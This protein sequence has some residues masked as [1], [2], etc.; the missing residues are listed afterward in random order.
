MTPMHE[1]G[2]LL[3]G[4]GAETD[5]PADTII[6]GVC[7]LDDAR[8]GHL[9]FCESQDRVEKLETCPA[10]AILVSRR[11][12]ACAAP[13][14]RVDTPRRAFGRI[15]Q[16]FA[17]EEPMPAGIHPTAVIEAG[18]ELAEGVGV[19]AL[20]YIGA[21]ARIGPNT[22]IMPQ[23][24]IGANASIGA[25]CLLRS[26]VRVERECVLGNRVIVHGGA[27]IGTDGFGFSPGERGIEKE[28]QLGH[29]RIGDDVEIG[30]N[31]TIDRATIPGSA[32]EIGDGTKIDNLVQIA[33][34]CKIGKHCV[35]VANV[36]ISGSVH[37]GDGVTMAGQTGVRDH[38]VIGAGARLGGRAGVTSDVPGGATYSGYPAQDHRKEL[39]QQAALR[40]LPDLLQRVK[41]LEARLAALSEDG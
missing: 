12:P 26:G 27:V 32:T 11:F 36:G 17:P 23:C 34:N 16:R 15:M 35:I 9:V 33:H 29:V 28:P 24:Y 20:A 18:A 19:G 2:D 1:L 14:V 31:T 4:L 22:R 13:L 30:S 39:R 3:A 37:V 5:L 38:V 41:A 40:K 25:D 8:P 7:A 21:L 6:A 10:A